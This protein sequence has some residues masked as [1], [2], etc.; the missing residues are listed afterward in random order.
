MSLSAY[1]R[2]LYIGLW[3]EAYDDGV[4]EWKP[5]TLKARLFPVDSVDVP[6][7]LVEL[8]K[9]GLIARAEQ[10]PKQ[11]GLIRN[12]QKFQ[13]PKKP[14]SS[15]MLEERWRDYVGVSSEPVPY[16]SGTGTEKPSLME[17]EG[18]SKD[19]SEA[20]A[21]SSPEP[22]KAAPVASSPT[23]IDLPCVSGEPYPVSEADVAEWRTAF[24]A[25]DIRQQ[26]AS[27]RQWLIANDKRRKTRKGMRRFIVAWLDR[28]QNE[29]G[30]PQSQ[31]TS[32]P[33]KHSPFDDLAEIERLKGW[34]DEPGSLPRSDEND[35]RISAV[36]R[37]HPS[38]VVDL[39]RGHDWYPGRSDH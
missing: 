20:N 6:E 27:M 7:L 14:N 32:P 15:G 3:G 10:H 33:R 37:G 35:Q 19:S 8:Y 39:R 18:G 25:V 2:L 12:F 31:S 23:A 38:P 34:T 13:R 29:G 21:S 16:R 5:L 36:E 24:P 4:F 1:A 11:P 9:A 28:K 22:A 30:R 17:D 26:L